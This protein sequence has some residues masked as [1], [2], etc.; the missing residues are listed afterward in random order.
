[1]PL[2]SAS[3]EKFTAEDA[4]ADNDR[5]PQARPLTDRKAAS[6]QIIREATKPLTESFE[7]TVLADNLFSQAP[8]ARYPRSA[9]ASMTEDGGRENL[10]EEEP[11]ARPLSGRMAAF[12]QII[13]DRPPTENFEQTFSAYEASTM[14][15]L[16][17]AREEKITV[18]LEKEKQKKQEGVVNQIKK[19]ADWWMAKLQKKKNRK[20]KSAVQV[21]IF[22]P[23]Q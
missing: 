6:T 17:S 15:K 19:Q 20:N 9:I 7:Q 3:E 10:A 23:N 2:M 1:M 11:Q 8:E 14:D 18:E 4:Q 21:T 5:P 13:P 22:Y 16:V 12:T